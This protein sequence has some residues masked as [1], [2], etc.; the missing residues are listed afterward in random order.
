MIPKCC[1]D[2]AREE[3]CIWKGVGWGSGSVQIAETMATLRGLYP[4]P[5]RTLW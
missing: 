4:T 3:T 5:F 1:A 2:T